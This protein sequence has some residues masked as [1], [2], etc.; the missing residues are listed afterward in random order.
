MEPTYTFANTAP[1]FQLNWALSLFGK[2]VLPAPNWLEQLKTDTEPDGVRILEYRSATAHVGQFFVSTKPDVSPEQIIRSVKGRWQHLIRK[3]YPSIF[4][5]NYYLGSVGKANCGALDR[6]V[7][8]Q[9]K[10]HA[11]AD[12][13]ISQ[14]LAALQFYDPTIDLTQVR[15]SRHGQFVYNLQVVLENENGWHDVRDDIFAKT[16]TMIVR[17]AAKKRWLLSRIGLLSNHLH[18]LLGAY[19]AESPAQVALS[20][21]NNLAYIQHMKAV[22]RF[23]Y[24]VGTFGPYD[25]YAIWRQST[26]VTLP[27]AQGRW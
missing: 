27:P 19:V 26:P 3:D 18:V 7:G 11:M 2:V 23:S 14:R 21:M 10:R 15:S 24:Y 25:R 6:Y 16:R 20:L 22:L 4:H 1:A 13:R 5:R 17:T 12:P 9:V 8:N